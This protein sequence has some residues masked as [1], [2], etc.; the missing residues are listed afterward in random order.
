M[1][2]PKTHSNYDMDH[3]CKQANSDLLVESDRDGADSE[4]TSQNLRLFFSCF[5]AIVKA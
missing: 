3:V 2:F 1:P 4:S 5:M